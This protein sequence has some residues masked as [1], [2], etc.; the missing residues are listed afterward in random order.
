MV[1]SV[2]L[3]YNVLYN[4]VDYTFSVMARLYSGL[5]NVM[6]FGT[7]LLMIPSTVKHITAIVHWDNVMKIGASSYNRLDTAVSNYST[8]KSLLLSRYLFKNTSDIDM[9]LN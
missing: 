4:A 3:C 8:F 5:G 1:V 7:T 9:N 2:I 6:I